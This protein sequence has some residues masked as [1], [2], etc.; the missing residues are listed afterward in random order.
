MS[1]HSNWNETNCFVEGQIRRVSRNMLI[2]NGL[3]LGILAT[4]IFLLRIYVICFL[5]GPQQFNDADILDVAKGQGSGLIA[6]VEIHD[7]PLIPT[8]YVEESSKDGQVY[9]TMNYYFVAVGDKK[10]LVKAAKDARGDRLLG[11]LQF[12]SAKT[13]Q[14]AQDAIVAKN[15]ALRGQVL[16]VMLNAAAAFNVFGYVLIGVFTPIF[17]WCMYNIARAILQGKTNLHPVM[18]SLARQGDPHELAQAIDAEMAA[19][20]VLKVGKAFITQNWLLRPTAFKLIVCRLDDIVWAYHSVVNHD[21]VAGLAFRDGRV[22]GIP[23]YRGTVELLAQI[24][25]RVPWIEK[26]W[27]QEKAKKW[28]TERSEF[29]AQVESR[30]TERRV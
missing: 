7:H 14:Q 26:G 15:P 24:Y 12:F 18:R 11:P 19:D 9:S 20:T 23:A 17:A 1:D 22:F 4:I 2:G 28:R 16:P 10:M 30:R 13:D 6:Y 8:G 25:Q 5:Q 27:D 3:V 29:L 21:N